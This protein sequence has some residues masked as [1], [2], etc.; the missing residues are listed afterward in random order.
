MILKVSKWCGICMSGIIKLQK[1][2]EHI[3]GAYAPNTVRAYR[4]DMLEFVAYCQGRGCCP[5]P[6]D[7]MD[8][9]AFLLRAGEQGIKMS[10]VKRKMSSISAIHRLSYLTDPTKHPEVKL[11][12]RKIARTLGGRF[13]QA[14]PVNY[15]LL[16]RLLAVCGNDTQG[17]RNQLLLRL[18]YD[19]LRRRS[20]L[21]SLRIEDIHWSTDHLASIELRKSKTDPFGTGV[22]LHL[23]TQ[24]SHALEAWLAHTQLRDGLILRGL[25]PVGGL[26]DGLSASHVNR[27]FKSLARQAGLSDQIIAGVSGHSMRVGGAQDLLRQGATL[28]QIMVK[29]GW[30]KTDT[31]MRYME[32]IRS[33]PVGLI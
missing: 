11:A 5:W 30:S 6:A 22:W 20:E 24:T 9:A 2:L 25:E 31:V 7:P 13:Q 23:N 17:L 3:E 18:A 21:V 33:S 1:L 32:Q 29:G 8:V 4:V 27:I 10:T 19:S 26:T 14:Y 16:L 28:P 12:M 15:A